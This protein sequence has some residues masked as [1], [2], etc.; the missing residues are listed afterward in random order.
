[1]GKTYPEIDQRIA[2]FLR[3]QHV[4]FVA[5]APLSAEG[6]VNLSPKGLQSFAV[7][8]PRTV[9]YLDLTGSGIETVAHLRENDRI[10]LM[11]CAFE[12]PPKILRLQGR[13]E[14]IERGHSEWD[15]LAARF[16]SHLGAR[17]VI[18]VRVER[19]AD[20]CGYAVPLMRYEGDRDQ[21]TLWAE[22]KG[23]EGLSAYR[24]AF[25]GTSIDGLPGLPSASEA[26][27]TPPTTSRGE[28]CPVAAAS[29]PAGFL[30]RA[31]GTRPR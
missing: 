21:L 29:E 20:S 23:S 10:T 26:I 16:P 30:A 4:F 11:F 7:L 22:R 2:E 31:E 17:A 13:G 14:A 12:G 3:K 24:A 6:R 5:T 25:N 8:D 18:R 19:I 15:A 9:A 28:A 1:M 27:Q